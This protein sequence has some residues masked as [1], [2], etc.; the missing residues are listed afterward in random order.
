MTRF[1]SNNPVRWRR[2]RP[3]FLQRYIQRF[4]NATLTPRGVFEQRSSLGGLPQPARKWIRTDQR[5]FFNIIQRWFN[6]DSTLMAAV[7]FERSWPANRGG[8][9]SNFIQRYFQRFVNATLT[10]RS[11][12]CIRGATGCPPYNKK[13]TNHKKMSHIYIYI[14]I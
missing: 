1:F 5:G 3:L 14:Y 10:P 6:A 8:R 11:V 7:G 4:V 13:L 2:E 9:E 12:L